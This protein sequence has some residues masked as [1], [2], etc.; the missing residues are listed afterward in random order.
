MFSQM[1]EDNQLTPVSF[2]DE[3]PTAPG[4]SLTRVNLERCIMIF[5]VLRS[6]TS[7]HHTLV[8][9]LDDY[10]A[11]VNVEHTKVVQRNRFSLCSLF[12]GVK[13]VDP[14]NITAWVWSFDAAMSYCS[15]RY[16]P[17]H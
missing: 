1:L 4:P 17:P 6:R 9:F 11:Q 12:G 15:P 2:N 3:A 8:Y 14:D 7:L 10:A 16:E 5:E 13:K